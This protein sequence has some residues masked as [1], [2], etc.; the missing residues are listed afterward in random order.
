MLTLPDDRTVHNIDWFLVWCVPFEINFGEV[1]VPNDLDVGDGS[2]E[3]P[4]LP[5]IEE[6]PTVSSKTDS[7]PV[8][9]LIRF[10]SKVTEHPEN[11]PT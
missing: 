8:V 11:K 3:V 1:R 10:S 9:N 7:F 4:T 2:V 5:P 6:C